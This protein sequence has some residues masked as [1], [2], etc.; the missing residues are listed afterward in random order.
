M[1]LPLPNHIDL[2]DDLYEGFR[3]NLCKGLVDS[4]RSALTAENF[5]VGSPKDCRLDGLK[6]SPVMELPV[7]GGTFGRMTTVVQRALSDVGITFTVE[8]IYGSNARR[9]CITLMQG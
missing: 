8:T 3:I 6:V 1:D 2:I 9:V 4:I 7:K 5:E